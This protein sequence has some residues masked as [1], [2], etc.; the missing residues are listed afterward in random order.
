[1]GGEGGG[2]RGR[3]VRAFPMAAITGPVVMAAAW[4]P[5]PSGGGLPASALAD[6]TSPASPPP[7]TAGGQSCFFATA[8][9]AAAVSVLSFVAGSLN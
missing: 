5:W 2:G 1:M 4:R 6:S 8:C 9:M 3:T 7:P